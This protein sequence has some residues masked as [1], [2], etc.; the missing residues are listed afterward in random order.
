MKKKHKLLNQRHLVGCLWLALVGLSACSSVEESNIPL[1]GKQIQFTTNVSLLKSVPSI[2]NQ[3]PAG[4][5]IGIFINED[6]ATPGTSYEQ[7]LLYI[8]NGNGNLAGEAQ[9][10]PANGNKIKISAYY[11]YKDMTDDE[12]LFSVQADQTTD[13]NIYASD[14]LYSGE[15]VTNSNPVS[16]SFKHKLSQ[17]SYELV[18]GTGNPDLTNAKVS[19]LNANTGIKFNRITGDLGETSEKR[20]VVLGTQGGIIVPQTIANGT[21]FIKIT[22]Q[23]GKEVIYSPTDA[24]IIE[25]GKKYTFKLSVNLNVATSIGTEVSEWGEGGSISGNAEE[26]GTDKLLPAEIF[27]DRAYTSSRYVFS[28][29]DL[30]RVK[31]LEIYDPKPLFE[32]KADYSIY[33]FN[34]EGESD[35]II[36]WDSYWPIIYPGNDRSIRTHAE[37]GSSVGMRVIHEEITRRTGTTYSTRTYTIDGKGR[38]ISIDKKTVYDSNENLTELTTEWSEEGAQRKSVQSYEYDNKNAPLKNVNMPAWLIEYF[39]GFINGAGL[40]NATK[41]TMKSYRNGELVLQEGAT[42]PYSESYELTYNDKNYL[43]SSKLTI[44]LSDGGV[45]VYNTTITYLN[46]K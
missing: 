19:I 2:G 35:E 12:Y 25:S 24:V 44:N 39:S 45:S 29:D 20:E 3:L 40:N 27:Y 28:Y 8:S 31:T 46:W 32:D 26:P 43:T 18:A 17:I 16:I 9:Y 14:L 21:Q 34:Y 1:A 11:P 13:E 33:T 4:S 15:M 7:N 38:N 30:N 42:E 37:I 23:S 10:Y 22:L 6:A 41:Y 5:Q 36:G